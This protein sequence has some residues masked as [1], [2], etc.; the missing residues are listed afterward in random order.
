MDEH[1][2][3][4]GGQVGGEEATL[5]CAVCKATLE[6]EPY[7]CG[8]CDYLVCDHCVR[9]CDVRHCE[10]IR[11]VRCIYVKKTCPLCDRERASPIE[12][13][14]HCTKHVD[15]DPC[16]QCEGHRYD[17]PFHDVFLI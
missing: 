2:V 13:C 12:V 1:R 10:E 16:D 5:E 8:A 17:A 14:Y 4:E 7:E 9:L 15:P 3:V 11:C 6:V